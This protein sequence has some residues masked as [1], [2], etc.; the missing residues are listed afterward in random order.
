MLGPLTTGG[1]TADG[2]V[3]AIQE[4]NGAEEIFG[5]NL[6]VLQRG[7]QVLF[8]SMPASDVAIRESLQAA[9]PKDGSALRNAVEIYVFCSATT[10]LKV[11]TEKPPKEV[12]LD[13]TLVAAPQAGGFISFARLSKGEHTI[14][15]VF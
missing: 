6:K 5:G 4:G 2:D 13:Q 11:F 1:L 3:L 9:D 12:R 15:I 14:F 10:D 7:T 8:S